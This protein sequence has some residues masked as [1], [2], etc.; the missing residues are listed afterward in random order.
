M[1]SQRRENYW[2]A[3]IAQ[4]RATLHWSQE[5]FAEELHS[6][7][8]TVSRWEKGVVLPSY[9]KKARIEAL[10]EQAHLSSFQGIANVVRQS[11]FPMLLCD[12]RHLVIA[13]SACSG[14]SENQGV[15]EQTPQAQH[16]YYLQFMQ[17]I[18]DSGFWIR[19]GQRLDYDFV[20]PQG[21]GHRAVLV[22]ITVQG[23]IYAVVQDKA[24]RT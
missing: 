11:P 22:S 5:R 1:D 24:W 13:A 21:V 19:S 10:A 4:L 12:R 3:L 23:V 16:A 6:N 7:Q 15:L 18:E 20:D 9:A 8:A 17:V 14:F 2:G